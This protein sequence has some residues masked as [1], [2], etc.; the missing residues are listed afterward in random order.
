MLEREGVAGLT[1]RAVAAEAGVAPMGVYNHFDGKP[2]LLLAVLQR[3]FDGL[4][5]A[6]TVSSSV[7]AE[8]APG[9][10]RPRLP[11]LRAGQSRRRTG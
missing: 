8:R 10:V 4:R 6:V 5:E 2:G 1:V 7:P 9:R 3:A 11:P